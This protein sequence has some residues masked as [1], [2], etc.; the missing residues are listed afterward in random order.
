MYSII[1]GTSWRS[2]TSFGIMLVCKVLPKS[3]LLCRMIFISER[4]EKQP[5]LSSGK[6]D[7]LR[8][9]ILLHLIR[10]EGRILCSPEHGKLCFEA[11][12]TQFVPQNNLPCRGLKK[13]SEVRFFG[14]FKMDLR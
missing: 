5:A 11:L 8:L 13:P 7:S 4:I 6:K 3:F 2:M 12:E 14:E 1:V 10:P 9:S